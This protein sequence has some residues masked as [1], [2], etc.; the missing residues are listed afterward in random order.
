LG[1]LG[2]D[3]KKIKK[4]EKKKEKQVCTNLVIEI[5]ILLYYLDMLHSPAICGREKKMLSSQSSSI[6]LL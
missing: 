2:H 1:L 6:E 4:K 3:V 5:V